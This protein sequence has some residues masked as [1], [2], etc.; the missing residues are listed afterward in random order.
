MN[1]K[2]KILIADDHKE[3]LTE[4]EAIYNNAPIIL[5][6]ID[7]QG[8]VRKANCNGDPAATQKLAKEIGFQL[9]QVL[10]CRNTILYSEGCGQTKGCKKC[11]IQR[12]IA[13]TLKTGENQEGIEVGIPADSNTPDRS[14]FLLSTSY[15]VLQNEPYVLA[16]LL[17][18]TARK[19]AELAL[20]DEKDRVQQYLDVA[21]VMLLA[22]DREG[23]V[24]MINQKGAEILEYPIEEIVGKNWFDFFLSPECRIE[25]MTVSRSLLEG[26][27][28]A[29]EYHEIT[30]RTQSGGERLLACHCVPLRN[31]KGDIIGY[32]SSGEDIT[33]KRKL[34]EQLRLSQRLE[35][36]GTLA[37][38]VAHDFN[39]LLMG[40]DGYV[41]LLRENLGSEKPEAY[42]AEISKCV[43]SAARLSRQLLAFA[44]KEPIRPKIL[45]LNHSI[46][47]MLKLLQRLIGEDIEL[48][49]KPNESLWPVKL[50]PGQIDQIL[51]N[52]C[53]NARDAIGGIGR[54]SIETSNKIIKEAEEFFPHV[55]PGYYVTLTI[56]DNGCGMNMETQKHIF[57]P[58]FTSKEVGKGTGLGLATVYGIVKQNHGYIYVK[59]DLGV[60]TTFNIYLPSCEQ[61]DSAAGNIEKSGRTGTEKILLVE[62]DEGVRRITKTYLIRLGYCVV[63]A[64]HPKDALKL[65]ADNPD[66]DLL[67]T[68]VVMP[69]LGG[70]ELARKVAKL[71]P[72]AKILFMSG[73]TDDIIASH[74][75]LNDGIHL[76]NKPFSRDQLAQKLRDLLDKQAALKDKPL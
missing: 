22:I 67:L 9:G 20:R 55:K 53:V 74:G 46:G 29:N 62:D 49:W 58:F 52:L 3:N 11:I 37:G 16:A 33:E 10:H 43:E 34:E 66:I 51:T 61:D 63:E 30:V 21:G 17:D 48:S 12:T 59:S 7:Q 23:I 47:H 50:D 1:N 70:H 2:P 19:N 5:L 4:L 28:T 71:L 14:F 25:L 54:I 75:V 72:K 41:Y 68:D 44:R 42:L 56:S 26:D 57:E 18:I 73:Y 32:L 36:I 39:N 13:H 27:E 40:I 8:I 15:I 76:L 6:L 65:A 35:S 60:G 64:E 31:V 38:G 45:N 24:T 69:E